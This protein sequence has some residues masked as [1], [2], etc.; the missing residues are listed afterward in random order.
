MKKLLPLLF[1][2]L[3]L[4]LSIAN[5][6]PVPNSFVLS[7]LYFDAEGKWTIELSFIGYSFLETNDIFIRTLSGYSQLKT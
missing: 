2:L 4:Q 6:L 7:E 5:P 3:S 1:L